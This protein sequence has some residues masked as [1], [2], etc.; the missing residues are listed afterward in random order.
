[1]EVLPGDLDDPRVLDLL[2]DHLAGMHANSPP[3]SVHALDVSALRAR[4]V[5]FCTVWDGDA[6][7]GCGALAEL[8][9]SSGELKSMRTAA[10]HLRRGVGAHMLVHLL[11]L[12]RSRG[13]RRV[14]LETGSG[15]S[16]EAALALYRK[17]GFVSCPAFGT[18][19]PTDF[20][21]FLALD[22]SPP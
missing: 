21:Q 10:A 15:P 14:C 13:Y 7:L 8:D 9:A 22:L 1:M 12:A 19:A 3:G 17:H 4:H 5:T 11:G 2:R 20:N 6:L 16:F 18:Y